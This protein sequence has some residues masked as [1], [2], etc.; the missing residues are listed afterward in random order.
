MNTTGWGEWV[1]LE[2][3]INKMEYSSVFRLSGQKYKLIGPLKATKQIWE[4]WQNILV[5]GNLKWF[6][7]ESLNTSN[8]EDQG[9]ILKKIKNEG[10][11]VIGNLFDQEGN[12]W[13]MERI[14]NLIG[15]KYWVHAAGI[16]KLLKDIVRDTKENKATPLEMI[17]KKMPE[18][19]GII[20]FIYRIILEH[21]CKI[22]DILR[23]VWERDLNLSSED[24][25]L[26]IQEIKRNKCT[27]IKE[28]QMKLLGRWYRTPSQLALFNKN[29]SAKCWHCGES[30]GFYIHMWWDCPCVQKFW[31]N[32]IKEINKII[33]KDVQLTKENC[34]TLKLKN[35]E[36]KNNEEKA[37]KIILKAAHAVIALGWKD[38]NNWTSTKVDMYL[39]ENLLFEIIRDRRLRY[40]GERKEK[41]WN[42]GWDILLEKVKGNMEY[43]E[44]N[45]VIKSHITNGMY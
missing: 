27:R 34:I 41:A 17:I 18:G 33:G 21:Q 28:Q 12:P 39:A 23:R 1:R 25:Q 43:K 2:R 37:I 16:N 11:R 10:I 22:V 32:V 36:L 26:W 6:P 14:T 20:G 15:S 7:I 40:S 3:L 42:R 5:N 9:R 8:N 44:V 38:S 19:K 30:K 31:D 35:K 29:L 4:K 24:I 13:G 45:N